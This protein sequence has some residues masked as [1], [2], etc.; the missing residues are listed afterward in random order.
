[1][2]L[3]II[4]IILHIFGYV[5]RTYGSNLKS[6]H[7]SYFYT[8]QFSLA[9]QPF[10]TLALYPHGD[11]KPLVFNVPYDNIYDISE[12]F[13]P[14]IIFWKFLHQVGRNI[15]DPRHHL[16][17][18]QGTNCVTDC[19]NFCTLWE[20]VCTCIFYFLDFICI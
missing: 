16:T 8:H 15:C 5:L 2:T 7:H 1:M 19:L 9:A 14:H 11:T 4:G 6:I 12:Y 3:V 13:Q 18:I 10:P 17:A 20:G